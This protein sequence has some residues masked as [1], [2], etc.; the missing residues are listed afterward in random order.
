MNIK[1]D[2]NKILNNLKIAR[3][4]ICEN[5]MI[6]NYEMPYCNEEHTKEFLQSAFD[7]KEYLQLAEVTLSKL[8]RENKKLK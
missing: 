6:L 5:I 4:S 1:E 8:L 2:R 3:N 7:A